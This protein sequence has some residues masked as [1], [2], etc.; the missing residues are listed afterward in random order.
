MVWG[1]VGWLPMVTPVLYPG[2]II[3]LAVP[4]SNQKHLEEQNELFKES[5]SNL[6]VTVVV[7]TGNERLTHPVVVAIFRKRQPE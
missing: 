1:E 2:D 5:Y 7:I 6:G 4:A 3:H